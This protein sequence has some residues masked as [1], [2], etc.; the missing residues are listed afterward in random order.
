MN[1]YLR[2]LQM[3][4]MAPEGGAGGTGGV[5]GT[6]GAGGAGGAGGSGGGSA[7]SGEGTGAG[8]A[9]GE[10]SGG[11]AGSGA[12]G[13]A[14]GSGEGAGAGGEKMFKQA[15]V[16]QIVSER[17]ARENKNIE[18]RI[19][20]AVTSAVAETERK[21]KM[22]ADER[23]KA[24]EAE[25][26]RKLKERENQI[27]VREL[28]A[29]AMEKLAEKGLPKSLADVLVYTDAKTCEESMTALE[30]AFRAAVQSG[31]DERLRGGNP[32]G[33]GGKGDQ[34]GKPDYDKMT[35]EQY[36]ADL[37]ARKKKG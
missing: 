14:A 26:E 29:G 32:P 30:T 13:G 15:E 24:E 11:G 36:Y 20:D 22:T 3:R 16:N 9:G 37:E 34:G 33:G 21:A 25:A 35:D 27:T 31:V 12:G 17:L 1:N 8:G 6:G 19:A 28:R 2:L 18:Q 23:K 10:G 5:G 4:R 7:G